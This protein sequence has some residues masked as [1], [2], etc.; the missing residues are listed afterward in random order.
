[1]HSYDLS[2]V[3][4]TCNRAEL[5]S[6]S[7]RSLRTG[8][9]CRLEVIVVDGASTDDTAKVLAL[10]QV[11]WGDA[12][13]VVRE[14]RREGFV[15]AANKGFACATGR[16]V[17]WLNDDAR[18]LPGALDI[19]VNQLDRSSPMVGMVAL[20]HRVNTDRNIAY[21][22]EYNHQTYRLCH[23]RG[24]LY[25]NFGMIRRHTLNA[26]GRFDPRYYLYGADPDLSLK[27]WH[28]GYRVEPAHGALIEH[29]EHTDDRRDTD[30]ARGVADNAAL[31]AKWL[32]P[33]K[34][35]F[36]N[37]FDPTNPNTSMGLRGS[38]EWAEAA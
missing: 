13:Q 28:H 33:A 29:D 3:L 31:F 14:P 16:N 8:A 38:H 34:N 10:A 32:L 6:R 9:N 25:A 35:P 18:P 11:G 17:M 26:L 1:M 30:T 37:D 2:I 27:C 36:R 19:A 24:T 15:R 7:L 21:E 23:V 12:L 20:F 5:L 22:F 4:P